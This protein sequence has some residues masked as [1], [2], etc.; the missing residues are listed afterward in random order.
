MVDE[1]FTLV[2]RETALRRYRDARSDSWRGHAWVESC[3]A[4]R[5]VH[6]EI[7][8]RC[9]LRCRFCYNDSRGRE[10]S[11][12]PE[13]RLS[14]IAEELGG[15]EVL[16][17]TLSGGEALSQPRS[18]WPVAERLHRH[19]VALRLV[20][21]GWYLTEEVAERLAAT[22]FVHV[23][24][25]LD[26]A[27]AQIH[28][29]LRG[30]TGSWR[31]AILA[32]GS[33]SRARVA[34][35]VTCVLTSANVESLESVVEI[36]DLLGVERVVFEDLRDAG[37]GATEGAGLRLSDEEYEAVY[38]RLRAASSR[39]RGTS[40][41]VF[42]SDATFALEILAAR[43]PFTCCIRSNGDVVPVEAVPK[44]YGNLGRIGFATAWRHLVEAHAAGEYDR[45]VMAWA[46]WATPRFGLSRSAA[47]RPGAPT[48]RPGDDGRAA[49]AAR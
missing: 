10:V 12:L 46:G 14:Q 2:P 16:E 35:S 45:H 31:R 36:G 41:V 38:S 9:N 24:V 49:V 30:V 15:L 6:W 33:L 5:S 48:R 4:P 11:P 7:T 39:P 34:R 43:P 26:G 27:S 44:S 3:K 47:A 42:G 8:N 32:L 37:R 29:G 19:G 13:R 1:A 18:F 22:G 21:N 23:T 40:R 28:D 20:T 25:S 17:V